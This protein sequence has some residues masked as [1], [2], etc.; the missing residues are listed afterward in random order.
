M[1]ALTDEA[2]N[3]TGD[4]AHTFEEDGAAKLTDGV[5]FGLIVATN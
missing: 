2:L 3:V 5:T 4:D 1:P